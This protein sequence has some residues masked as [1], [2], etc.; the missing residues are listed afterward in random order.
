MKDELK[1]DTFLCFALYTANH[2]MNRVY[3]PLLEEMDVT[4]PQFLVLVTLWEED[5][6]TVGSI[7]E[8]LFLESST[9]TPLLKRLEAAGYIT[10]ARSRKDERQVIIRLTDQG[11]AMKGKAESI[12]GN[13]IAATGCSSDEVQ[14]LRQEISDLRTALDKKASA[15]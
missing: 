1:L 7:G 4:Y 13:I 2:A 5:E 14:R 12:P 9:L 15:A 11:R 3:K 8:K 6:Q 10:R